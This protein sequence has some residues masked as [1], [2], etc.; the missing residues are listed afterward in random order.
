[1]L[2]LYFKT[3]LL[4]RILVGLGAGAVAGL[5]FGPDIQWVAPLGDIFVRLL[6]LI[7]MPV[8]VFTLIVGAASIHPARLG[9]VGVKAL[10]LYT[11]T[12]AFAVGIG[13]LVGNVFKPGQGM[14]LA[15]TA[16]AG[17]L[18][19]EPTS[20]LQTVL[21]IVPLNPFKSITDGNM[22]QTI[23]FAILFGMGIAYL[24]ESKDERIRASANTVFAFFDGCAE[25]MYKVVNWILEYAP[26]GVFALIAVVFGEQGTEAFGPL[27]MV[28]LSVYVALILHL[29]VAYSGL[30]TGEPQRHKTVPVTLRAGDNTLVFALNHVSWQFQCKVDLLPVSDDKLDDLRYTAA[31]P[32]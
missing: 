9:R 23:F 10:L 4:L 32:R 28:T 27:G 13:L 1:M 12:T 21:E 11:V 7:V 30:L 5:I 25:V 26:I 31:P 15:G 19:A 24:R 8:V 22:L 20:L 3:N 2:R 6:K 17:G 14:T 29:V 18:K 16:G